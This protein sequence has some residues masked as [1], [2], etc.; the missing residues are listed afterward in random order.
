MSSPV[1]IFDMD[2]TLVDSNYYWSRASSWVLQS[3]G[4]ILD[5]EGDRALAST[6]YYRVPEH[7]ISRYHLACTE[8]EFSQKMDEWV[9]ERYKSDVLLRPSAMQYLQKLN[10][11]GVRCVILTASKQCFID[12]IVSRFGLEKLFAGT[13]SAATLGLEKSD[14]EIYH[15]IF[16]DL[17]CTASDCVMFE[18]SPYAV[19]MAKGL[20]IRCVGLLD[21]LFPAK[22]DQLVSLCDRTVK[23]YGELIDHDIF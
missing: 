3:L 6:G 18:D 14:P 9:L 22:F 12:T 2:G 1:A 16:S 4:V 11:K 19:S 17:D 15:R 21:P 5:D 13:Y 20:G 23:R 10:Q 8:Q 7:C